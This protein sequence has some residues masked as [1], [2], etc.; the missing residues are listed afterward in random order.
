MSGQ[1]AP[2][3]G[4]AIPV[5][6]DNP[7]ESTLNTLPQPIVPA[8]TNGSTSNAITSVTTVNEPTST[9]SSTDVDTDMINS[10]CSLL[11]HEEKTHYILTRFCLP[12]PTEIDPD[13]PPLCKYGKKSC[14]IKR[15]KVYKDGTPVFDLSPTVFIP[16]AGNLRV[17]K[18][19]IIDTRTYTCCVPNCSKP[20][21]SKAIKVFH[22]ACYMHACSQLFEEEDDRTIVMLQENDKILDYMKVNELERK[23][24]N[25]LFCTKTHVL[26]PVCG[27]RCFKSV[28]GYRTKEVIVLDE[29]IQDTPSA[30]ANWDKDAHGDKPSS[31]QLLIQWLTTEEN[32][33]L[34]FGGVNQAGK[35]TAMR[36]ECY[37]KVIKQFIKDRN[38]ECP[39]VIIYYI[40]LLLSKIY[41]KLITLIY[42]SIYVLIIILGVDR[43]TDSIRTKIQ[44]VLDSYFK[45]SDRLRDTGAG[46]DGSAYSTFHEM[47]KSTICRYYDELQPVLGD[48]P[49]VNAW[50]TNESDDKKIKWSKEEKSSDSSEESFMTSNE[51]DKEIAELLNSNKNESSEEMIVEI[52]DPPRYVGTKRSAL[53]ECPQKQSDLSTSDSSDDSL[54]NTRRPSSKAAS[55]NISA[56]SKADSESDKMRSST[57]SDSSLFT[58]RK[59]PSKVAS[60]HVNTYNRDF[61]EKNMEI[62]TLK[63]A[64]SVVSNGSP[65][66]KKKT[67]SD[68]RLISP[69]EAKDIQRKLMMRHKKQIHEKNKKNKLMGFVKNEIEEKDFLMKSRETKSFFEKERHVDMKRF[70][71]TK[72]SIDE[73]RCE[74]DERRYKM[75]VDNSELNKERI[76]AQTKLDEQKRMLVK[77]E[78]FKLRQSLKKEDPNVTDEYLDEH[79]PLN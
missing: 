56:S 36:K 8:T 38:G 34:Y 78:M 35:T 17:Y 15:S 16:H 65:K 61:E 42:I 72:I 48:R 66:K 1:G 30:P 21:K 68:K 47:V 60:R 69:I 40:T 53:K 76:K 77:L 19:N 6:Q 24:L 7:N 11:H 4:A 52:I 70:H 44:R 39:Y 28:T 18:Y 75:E 73:R 22:H 50:Y 59:S 3:L 26:F 37:H 74:I 13:N 33:S 62:N 49:N 57:N 32:A 14:M 63:D 2:P 5:T 27:K 67:D 55:R 31:I 10:V 41:S 71:D 43:T 12:V 20:T 25:H 54:F 64:I 79:F 51:D 23:V 46:L 45:A 58:S 29:L 9:V